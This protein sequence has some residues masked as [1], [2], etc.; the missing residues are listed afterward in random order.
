MSF[1]ALDDFLGASRKF[2]SENEVKFE[3]FMFLQGASNLGFT[4]HQFR[5]LSR[6]NKVFR[7]IRLTQVYAK[8]P[9]ERVVSQDRDR[10]P[11]SH[12]IL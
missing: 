6:A 11:L 3:P 10:G 12:R 8:D 4:P 1:H 2:Q 9:S 5:F 7:A